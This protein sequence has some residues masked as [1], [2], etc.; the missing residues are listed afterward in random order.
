[1]QLQLLQTAGS[2]NLQIAGSA[3]PAVLQLSS[4]D[5]NSNFFCNSPFWA[6][7]FIH[8]H[9]SCALSPPLLTAI[10]YGTLQ[11]AN[12][13]YPYYPR[14]FG[15]PTLHLLH[16][17]HP[18]TQTYKR[19]ALSVPYLPSYKLCV[20]PTISCISLCVR[21]LPFARPLTAIHSYPRAI[22]NFVF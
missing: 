4:A 20:I 6:S 14:P 3:S 13:A 5:S 7:S 17:T 15:P 12:S 10:Q 1:M 22:T 18:S 16:H 2:V 8:T 9:S 19:S 11:T 21:S